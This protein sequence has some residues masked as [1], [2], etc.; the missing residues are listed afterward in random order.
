MQLLLTARGIRIKWRHRN[1]SRRVQPTVS[2]GH[3]HA[4]TQPRAGRC[5]AQRSC[6][7]GRGAT[8]S[9]NAL[10]FDI[11]AATGTGPRRHRTKLPRGLAPAG[12]WC[13][14]VPSELPADGREPFGFATAFRSRAS[15]SAMV[16]PRSRVRRCFRPA[17]CVLGYPNAADIVG[18]C[19]RSAEN[20]TYVVI[21]QLEQDVRTFWDFWRA[22]AKTSRRRCGLQPKA[23]GRWPNGMPVH[24]SVPRRSRRSMKRVRWRLSSSARMRGDKVSLWCARSSGESARRSRRRPCGVDG[25]RPASS[26]G[27]ARVASMVRR[28]R[29]LVSG[30]HP[31]R[32]ARAAMPVAGRPRG[33]V[34]ICPVRGYRAAV[35]IRPAD[36]AEQPEVLRPLRRS[37]SDRGAVTAFRGTATVSRFLAPPLRCRMSGV[38]ALGAR[39]RRRLFFCRASGRCCDF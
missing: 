26:D 2:A 19:R 32:E 23:L 24:G 31:G 3:R 20:G 36:M 34:F 10:L 1:G 22:R 8:V 9:F 38:D 16:G 33:S 39:A 15:M 12:R 5:A 14:H 13:L 6:M 29:R 37:G 30:L 11:R 7:S 17:K 27:P 21:R 18:R 35:R 28:R 25:R 4:A